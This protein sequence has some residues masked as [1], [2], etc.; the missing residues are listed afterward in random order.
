MVAVMR[1]ALARRG[2]GFLANSCPIVG[3]YG[4]NDRTLQGPGYDQPSA[5][6]APRRIIAFFDAHRKA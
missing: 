2:T 6:D 1:E 3:Y 4:N 5:Q